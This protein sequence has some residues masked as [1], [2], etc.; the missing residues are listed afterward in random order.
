MVRIIYIRIRNYFRFRKTLLEYN[1]Y[2]KYS[3]FTMIPVEEYIRNLILAK[4]IKEIKGCIVE[5]GVWRGGMIA[6]ISEILGNQRNYYLFDSFEGLPIAKEI[7][8]KSAL[9]WQADKTAYGY[10][11]NCKAEIKYAKEAMQFS[12]NEKVHIT[13]GWFN[14]TLSHTQIIEP[15]ALLRLDADWYESTMQCL[16][17]LFDKVVPNGLIIIDDYYVWDGCSKACHDY[18]SKNNRSE[19]IFQFQGK[20][21]FIIKK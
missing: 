17:N 11:D 13:K 12:K 1:L 14:E 2:R 7:D 20:T 5:C 15:I 18:L 19:R 9:A 10:Y 8:G 4:R 3:K 6:G 21:A 16:D